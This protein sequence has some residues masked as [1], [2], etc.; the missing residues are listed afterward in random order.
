MDPFE[1]RMQF[2]GLLRKLN[3]TQ[4]SIQKV[5]S[6]ALK[7]FSRCG[8]DLW[9]CI[10]EECQKGSINHRI[11]ILYFLD[12]LCEASLLAKAHQPPP[13][14]S[15]SQA[16]QSNT[17]FYVDY[18]ARDLPQII[19]CVVPV[20]RQGLPNLTSTK[21]ILENWR[22]KRIIDPQR[23]DEVMHTLSTRQ[24]QAV[25]TPPAPALATPHLPRGEVFKRIEEDRER[26]K[27]LRERRWRHTR[28][29]ALASFLPLSDTENTEL[30]L[31]IEFENE[32]EATSDW[33]EDDVEAVSEERELCY[34]HLRKRVDGDGEEL[35]EGEGG[36]EPM[37]L[38]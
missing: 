28:H 15:S 26:H 25:D 35:A 6:Y 2:L 33:N 5:V 38:S 22:T 36:E 19:E 34:P 21:Q 14:E 10:V 23:I 16:K 11:N 3:A 7:Y 9:E 17:A 32:W 13:A 29:T 1:V 20:G 30:A 12:S 18:V 27:R 37:D 8:E 31:D 4:Q 24:S